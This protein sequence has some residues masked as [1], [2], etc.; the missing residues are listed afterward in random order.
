MGGGS[1]V[2]PPLPRQIPYM[3]SRVNNIGEAIER[4]NGVCSFCSP[5]IAI[6]NIYREQYPTLAK[7][8][9]IGEE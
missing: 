5:D 1:S 8:L 6:V 3:E 7:G 2:F 4:L 9:L